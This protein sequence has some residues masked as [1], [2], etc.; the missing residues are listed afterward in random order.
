MGS[1]HRNCCSSPLL[2]CWQRVAFEVALLTPVQQTVPPSRHPHLLMPAKP[3]GAGPSGVAVSAISHR[4]WLLQRQP[5]H[6]WLPAGPPASCSEEGFSLLC[7]G[8][9]AEAWTGQAPRWNAACRRLQYT[10]LR[11][12]P[13]AAAERPA[14][15]SLQF[16]QRSLLTAS[17]LAVRCIPWGR[18]AWLPCQTSAAGRALG[19]LAHQAVPA[20]PPCRFGRA[21]DQEHPLALRRCCIPTAGS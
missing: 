18:H 12:L 6:C 8:S 1:W 10:A 17:T 14:V 3:A 5:L 4:W 11:R 7:I 13:P 2:Q 19:A 9:G 16:W 20:P 21:A 15:A